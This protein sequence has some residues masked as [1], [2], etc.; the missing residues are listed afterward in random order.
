MTLLDATNEPGWLIAIGAIGVLIGNFLKNVF[1]FFDKWSANDRIKKD[2][3]N[4]LKEI[5]ILKTKYETMK[6]EI[7]AKDKVIHDLKEEFQ[8]I[9]GKLSILRQVLARDGYNDIEF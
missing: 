8:M 6:G 5:E 9:E 4:Y 7:A 2:L 1:P 3:E